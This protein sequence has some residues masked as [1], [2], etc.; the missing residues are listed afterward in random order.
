MLQ[1]IIDRPAPS[2]SAFLPVRPYSEA[3]I[4]MVVMPSRTPDKKRT[5]AMSPDI[6]DASNSANWDP[7]ATSPIAC[8][9]FVDYLVRVSGALVVAGRDCDLIDLTVCFNVPVFH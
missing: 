7:T 1:I 3:Y 2:P 4:K 9:D 6:D 5:W 8:I